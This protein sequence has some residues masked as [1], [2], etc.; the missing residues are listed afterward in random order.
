MI[1]FAERVDL[2]RL[3]IL[4]G[5]GLVAVVAAG[6]VQLGQMHYDLGGPRIRGF[7]LDG[8]KNIPT[9]VSAALVA[10]AAAL[11]FVLASKTSGRPPR[12]VLAAF[13]ILLAALGLD[14]ALQVHERLADRTSVEWQ[15]LYLPI[16]GAG[17]VVF[18]LLWRDLR[19]YPPAQLFLG[20]AAGA[21]FVAQ[22]VLE[23]VQRTPGYRLTRPWTIAPEEALELAGAALIVFALLTTLQHLAA[24]GAP[25]PAP[26]QSAD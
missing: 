26:A 24:R 4:M 20:G 22:A 9:A 6:T 15:I 10:S 25:A 3:G 1:R 11:S 18:L 12:S 14:D 7:Y 16:A 8:E 5:A 23:R 19:D 2:R 21:W 13:G 17:A